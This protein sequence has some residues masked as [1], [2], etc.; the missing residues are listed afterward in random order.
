MSEINNDPELTAIQSI[1]SALAPLEPEAQQRAFAYVAM[2]LRI[3]SAVTSDAGF[4]SLSPGVS[5]PPMQIDIRT[6][7][8]Q[9]TPRSANEMCAVIGYYLTEIAPIEERKSTIN[10]RDVEKYFKQAAFQLPQVLKQTLPNAAKAGY[11]DLVGRGEYKLT[12]VGHN[13]V[14]H[15]LPPKNT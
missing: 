13:L 11:F 3:S 5:A 1:M 12:P 15:S 6:L 10:R 2:R 14:V 7:K 8:E 9:K 4:A